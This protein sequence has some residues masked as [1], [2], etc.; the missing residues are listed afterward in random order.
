MRT[1]NSSSIL[2]GTEQFQWKLLWNGQASE[3]ASCSPA[4]DIGHSAAAIVCSART[5]QAHRH[6]VTPL[7][8]TT[9]IASHW[10]ECETA[11]GVNESEVS[12]GFYLSSV[13]LVFYLPFF[14]MI[15]FFS[16]QLSGHFGSLSLTGCP[17]L[18]PTFFIGHCLLRFC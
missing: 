13:R 6:V 7:D 10:P 5:S 15:F 3:S 8:R 12:A 16:S 11:F 9:S 17:D 2:G 18:Q 1:R 4:V 14:F